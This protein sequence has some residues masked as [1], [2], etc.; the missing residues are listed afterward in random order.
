MHAVYQP[1]HNECHAEITQMQWYSNMRR[2]R[3]LT[4]A[5]SRLKL[6]LFAVH[7][8]RIGCRLH[9]FLRT[10]VAFVRIRASSF[11]RVI[12]KYFSSLSLPTS[13]F[14]P[15]SIFLFF[16]FNSPRHLGFTII[17]FDLYLRSRISQSIVHVRKDLDY[18]MV[19]VNRTIVDELSRLRFLVEL[20]RCRLITFILKR[21]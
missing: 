2:N 5:F 10:R 7:F 21:H 6:R 14:S 9:N 3:G 13:L 1:W 8:N 11:H 4:R 18:I 20:D 17:T 16:S 15:T 19:N 12:L